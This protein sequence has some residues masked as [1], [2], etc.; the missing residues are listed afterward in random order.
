MAHIMT[1][2]VYSHVVSRKFPPTSHRQ[3]IYVLQSPQSRA[4]TVGYIQ[5]TPTGQVFIPA[6]LHFGP[7]RARDTFDA[8]VQ[9]LKLPETNIILHRYK[10]DHISTITIL[11][12]TLACRLG[13]ALSEVG[14]DGHFGDAYV[15]ATHV[16]GNGDIRTAYLYENTEGL[17]QAGLWILADSICMGRNTGATLTSLLAKFH[18]KEI[19]ILAPIASR[20]GLDIVGAAI[21]KY[22][23]PTTFIAWGGLFGVDK[24][25]LYDMPWGHPDTEPLDKRDQDLAV[26]MY[27]KKLCMGGDFGNNYYCPPLA[28]KLYNEQLKEHGIKPKIP[29]ALDVL[30][31]YK[32]EEILIR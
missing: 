26:S 6:R 4:L 21:A 19:L 8:T 9:S 25:T 18:P 31:I 14:I 3:S 15:G 20:R 2:N 12:E 17:A 10:P 11:R 24:T 7:P 30:S 1:K 16:K 5:T 29:Q 23:I 32:K 27:G 13:E 22:R 28:R